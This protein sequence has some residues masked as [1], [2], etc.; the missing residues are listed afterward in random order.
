MV[1]SITEGVYY[2]YNTEF[3]KADSVLQ[4]V[5]SAYPDYS[6]SYLLK[7]MIIYWQNYP[8]IPGSVEGSLFEE[9]LRKSIELAEEKLK[10]DENDAENLLTTLCSM[11]M[12]LM[13]YADNG[14]SK[15]VFLLAPRVY[16]YLMKSY[17]FTDIYPDF[18]FI[19][20]LYNYY[21]EAYP[22]VYPMYKPVFLFFPQG[23]K[24]TG[25]KQLK[26]ASDSAVFLKAESLVFLSGI[27]QS[28]ERDP[29]KAVF[30]SRKLTSLYP[31]NIF[32]RT[33][34]ICDLLLAKRYNE[35]EKYMLTL[36]ESDNQYLQ[37]QICVFKGI[38]SEK[39]YRNNLSAEEHYREGIQKAQDYRNFGNIYAAYGYFGLS[40]I[41]YEVDKKKVKQYRKQAKDLA[42]FEYINFDD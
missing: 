2:I 12:L 31:D 20:G 17:H 16:R 7:G 10:A 37:A 26:L 3:A 33:R 4:K 23:N 35:A 5:N 9:Q 24:K 29:K 1:E 19:T 25:L 38:L 40:R 8:V 15:N 14:L 13:Y 34:F 18:Y 41:Y 39:K 27:Y 11:G 28:F 22:E 6:I 36:Q 21:R 42:A 32:F 30:Y